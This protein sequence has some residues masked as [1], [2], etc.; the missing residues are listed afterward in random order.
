MKNFSKIKLYKPPVFAL[1]T[2]SYIPNVLLNALHSYFTKRVFVLKTKEMIGRKD[3]WK[4]CFKVVFSSQLLIILWYCQE[5]HGFA[6][7]R[8]WLHWIIIIAKIMHLRSH[9]VAQ[10]YLLEIIHIILDLLKL[11]KYYW[12]LMFSFKSWLLLTI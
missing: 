2:V 8:L 12:E 6:L 5:L 11:F 7:N 3:Y 1:K 4:L 9:S 10:T